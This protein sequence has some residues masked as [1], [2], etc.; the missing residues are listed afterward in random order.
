MPDD[1]RDRLA[2]GRDSRARR[3]EDTIWWVSW[4]GLVAAAVALTAGVVV[5]SK[6][7]VVRCPDGKMFPN[8]T[9]DFNCYSHPQAALGIGVAALAVT[10]GVV[11]VLMNITGRAVVTARQP[12][13]EGPTSASR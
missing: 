8:G 10:L 6:R 4:I 13:S 9:T 2:E 11:V 1:T 3:A 5:A 7:I 12:L